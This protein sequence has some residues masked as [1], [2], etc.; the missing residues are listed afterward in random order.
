MAHPAETYEEESSEEDS[1]HTLSDQIVNKYE[2]STFDTGEKQYLP[3]V[4]V[5]ELLTLENIVK[6]LDD[7]NV[8]GPGDLDLQADQEKKAIVDYILSQPARTVFAIVV[9]VGSGQLRGQTLRSLI[10]SLMRTGLV[11]A[12]LPATE[13]YF[14]THHWISSKNRPARPWKPAT[15]NDFLQKQWIFLAPVFSPTKFQF[16]LR[17]NYILPMVVKPSSRKRRGNFATVF[18]VE[19]HSAHL[20][21]ESRNVRPSTT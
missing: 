3:V 20:R 6:E 10:A 8:L 7:K 14:R 9:V 5:E 17:P 12:K 13:N 15:V 19:V 16:D 1:V 11:D 4:Y 2:I 18:E 21:H